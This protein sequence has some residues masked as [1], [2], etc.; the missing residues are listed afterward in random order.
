MKNAAQ[1]LL[2]SLD[3]SYPVIDNAQTSLLHAWQ[4]LEVSPTLQ[5]NVQV[6]AVVGSNPA[7][8][9]FVNLV[10]YGIKSGSF[11]DIVG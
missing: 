2:L 10:N 9:I 5:I 3:I 1:S 11:E 6:A 8:F 4:L 7:S